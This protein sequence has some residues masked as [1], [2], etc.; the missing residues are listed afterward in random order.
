MIQIFDK[1]LQTKNKPKFKDDD[2]EFINNYIETY[3]GREVV[4]DRPQDPSFEI[5]VDEYQIYL[6]TS[7]FA[8]SYGPR[9]LLLDDGIYLNGK[10]SFKRQKEAALNIIENVFELK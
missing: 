10:S 7:G 5:S 3:A 8:G 9:V 2:E 4:Y 6:K 1:H